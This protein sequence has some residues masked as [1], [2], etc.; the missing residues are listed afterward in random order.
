MLLTGCWSARVKPANGFT[1]I[2]IVV[3]IGIFAIIAAIAYPGMI[4]FLDVR[5]AIMQRSEQISSIQK[6]VT[7]LEN[8]LRFALNRSVRNEYGDTEAAWDTEVRSDELFRMTAAYPDLALGGS[9]IPKRVA[10]AWDGDNLLRR[11]WRVLDRTVDSE[12]RERIILADIEGV[13]VRYAE[14]DPEG[15][16]SLNW[17][18]RFDNEQQSVPPALEIIIRVNSDIEF[19]RIFEIPVGGVE[20]T[21]EVQ[22]GDNAN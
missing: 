16:D 4:Q 2:E 18:T 21:V 13:E 3:A 6:S 1:L 22:G 10:W 9:A 20:S 5:D 15:G 19:R 14:I 17:S 8:D 12:A 7:F 11:E